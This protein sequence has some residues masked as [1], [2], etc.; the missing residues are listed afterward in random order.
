VRG[1]NGDETAGIPGAARAARALLRGLSN[2]MSTA[3]RP[4][5]RSLVTDTLAGVSVEYVVVVGVVAVASIPAF[6][7]A[8]SSLLSGF[9]WMRHLLFYPAP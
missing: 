7:F 1:V 2:P 6:L 3:N 8:G 5:R 9:G 4:Q